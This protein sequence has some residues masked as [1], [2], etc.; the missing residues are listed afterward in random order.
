MCV[1]EPD[2]LK[3]IFVRVQLQFEGF[4]NA[5]QPQKKKKKT[6][7]KSVRPVFAFSYDV[8]RSHQSCASENISWIE[9]ALIHVLSLIDE[10]K[11]GSH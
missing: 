3:D 11:D 8:K 1:E 7:C 10:S 6:Y 9:S 2:Y 5:T 4:D